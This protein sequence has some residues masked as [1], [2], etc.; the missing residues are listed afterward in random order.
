[1]MERRA[2]RMLKDIHD[3]RKTW[4]DVAAEA[5]P[6]LQEMFKENLE[7]LS[8]NSKYEAMM[9]NLGPSNLV[10]IHPERQQSRMDILKKA[11][12]NGALFNDFR[13]T[14]KHPAVSAGALAGM[15]GGY[16]LSKMTEK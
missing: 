7:L 5:R 11:L 1:D 2:L 6:T 3:G 16:Y 8:D 12:P 10:R 13:K 15:T 14:L 9:N 4:N